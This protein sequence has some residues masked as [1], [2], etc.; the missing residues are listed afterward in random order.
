MAEPDVPE[1]VAKPAL[2]R[3]KSNL[4]FK[5]SPFFVFE[6]MPSRKKESVY[7]VI[8]DFASHLGLLLM[9]KPVS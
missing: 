1:T 2:S 4:D 3:S 6:W 7:P 9:E 5:N 8:R